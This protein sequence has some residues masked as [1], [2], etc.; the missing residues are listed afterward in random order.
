MGPPMRS[1]NSRSASASMR[2]TFSPV[3]DMVNCKQDG[4]KI[5][6]EHLP[7]CFLAAEMAVASFVL[8]SA[9][10]RCYHVR[11]ASMDIAYIAQ[12]KIRVKRGDAAPAIMESKFGATVRQRALDLGKRNAWKTQG[13]GAQFM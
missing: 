8:L 11:H 4:N 3:F 13:T 9:K 6:A 12:G 5:A 2:T 1:A 7:R 10:T